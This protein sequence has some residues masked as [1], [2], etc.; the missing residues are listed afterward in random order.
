MGKQLQPPLLWTLFLSSVFVLVSEAVLVSDKRAL[1]F[2]TVI[3]KY[4]VEITRDKWIGQDVSS[5][6][7]PER[8]A[9][10]R[11][12]VAQAFPNAT[13]SWAFSWHALLA[14]SD[15]FMAIKKLVV[16]YIHQYGDEMTFI[17]GGYFAPMYN[18]ADQINLDMHDALLIISS[19]VGNPTY[20][21]K[22]IVAGFMSA[23]SARYLAEHENIHVVQGQIFS[24]F[25]I[26]YGD[27]DGGQPYP[28]F[29]STEHYL[30]PAQGAD[31][32]IDIVVLDGWSVDLL[33]YVFFL[34]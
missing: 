34:F 15:N 29:P 27:G 1:A 2:S 5:L 3:R 13:M 6:Q 22:S 33:K 14:C 8:A 23:T 25:D 9:A 7:T 10:M 17:P 24:Q 31:D 16:S 26:D 4:P 11:A 32:A 21:P 20:R 28:Y 19:I 18:N 30:K 12:A